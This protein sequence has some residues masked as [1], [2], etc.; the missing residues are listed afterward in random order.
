MQPVPIHAIP[1]LA[2]VLAKV[3]SGGLWY[4]PPLFLKEWQRLS[5]VSDEAMKGGW[6]TGALVWVGGAIVTAFVLSH[7]VYYAG[8]HSAVTGAAVGLFN[9]LGF[10]LVVHLDDWAAAKRPF[11]LVAI[12]AGNGLVGLVLMGAIFG[13]WG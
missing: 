2:A 8:A 6:A 3:V 13:A 10:V 4:S 12:N 1:F 9:W 7:A 11:K 5:N